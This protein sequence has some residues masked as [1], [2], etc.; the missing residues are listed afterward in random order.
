MRAGLQGEVL[1]VHAEGVEADRLEDV[2]A[3]QAL[4]SS[5][6]VHAEERIA[7][8]D[9]QPLRRGVREHHQVVVR[10]GRAGEIRRVQARLLPALLP[11]SLKPCVVVRHG[12]EI[13]ATPP[14][15]GE[16][17][18]IPIRP[19]PAL[20]LVYTDHMSPLMR[21]IEQFGICMVLAL[22]VSCVAKNPDPRSLPPRELHLEGIDLICISPGSFIV[23]SEQT[24]PERRISIE[25][26]FYLSRY[27]ITN[28]QFHRFLQE[29]SYDGK[30]RELL[31]N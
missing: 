25:H 8:P 19:N 2:V 17:I 6:A 27:E 24:P 22:A 14:F 5:P 1:T 29:T 13:V 9:M 3:L 15:R 23:G 26:S 10:L 31:G 4:V 11:F 30:P 7:V 21:G 16:A 20:S 18:Q 28:T 12:A